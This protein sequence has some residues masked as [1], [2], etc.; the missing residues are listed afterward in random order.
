MRP[1]E[2]L[3]AIVEESIAS[4]AGSSMILVGPHGC[5]K[6][7]NISKVICAYP[8]LPVVHFPGALA[9]P[10]LCPDPQGALLAL[11]PDS[12]GV[13]SFEDYFSNIPGT[14]LLVMEDLDLFGG[15]ISEQAFLYSLFDLT[16]SHPLVILATTCR[17]VRT[18]AYMFRISWSFSKRGSRVGLAIISFPYQCRRLKSTRNASSSWGW[19]KMRRR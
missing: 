9:R 12:T 2:Q 14:L 15:G 8:D 17:Q 16:L 13:S 19:K 5:G 4:K 1:E 11:L 10:S 3:R 18:I 6:T 7:H